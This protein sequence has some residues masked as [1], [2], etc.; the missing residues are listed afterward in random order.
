M[1]LREGVTEYVP[2]H[3]ISVGRAEKLAARAG[4]PLEQQW[5]TYQRKK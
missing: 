5:I 4:V 1:Q 3:I 2:F